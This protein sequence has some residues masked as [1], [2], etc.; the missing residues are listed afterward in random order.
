MRFLDDT[1]PTLAENLAVDE[2]LLLQAQAGQ[3]GEV[4]RLWEWPRLAVVLGSG[5]RLAEDVVEETCQADAVPIVRRSSGGGTVLLGRGCLLY[6]LVLRYERAPP[7]SEIPSSYRFILHHVAAALSDPAAQVEQEGISDLALGG[8]KFSG[9]AQQR[10]R[11]HLL[12]HGTILYD[13][14]LTCVARYLR[15]P[16]RQPD[17]RAGRDHLAFLH[18]LPLSTAEIRSRLRSAWQAETE[19]VRWDEELVKQL[20]RDKYDLETWTR[21][22]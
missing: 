7:L 14:D 18:N 10:K 17:Y 6:S 13:F 22:R 12:H 4:L 16:P 1:R 5:C 21:R 19:G 3:G 20:C 9:N 2:A 11:T 15:P 8:R